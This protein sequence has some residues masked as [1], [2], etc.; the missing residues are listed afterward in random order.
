VLTSI[1]LDQGTEIH[2]ITPSRVCESDNSVCSVRCK[3]AEQTAKIGRGETLRFRANAAF[4][5]VA[6]ATIVPVAHADAPDDQFTNSLGTQGITGDR[7]QLIGDGHAMCDAYASARTIGLM[8]QIEGQGF[9][10]TQASN[11][12]LAGLRAYCLERSASVIT[13]EGWE[14]DR[15]SARL[16]S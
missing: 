2:A 15:P 16:I 8:L 5:G 3:P 6:I 1:T 7:G 11:V 9:D 12:M 13:F 14:P 4:P 10:K